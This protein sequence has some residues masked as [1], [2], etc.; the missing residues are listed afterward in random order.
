MGPDSGVK[1]FNSGPKPVAGH[2]YNYNT[3]TGCL[4]LS[5]W[6]SNARHKK[7]GPTYLRILMQL[8]MFHFF[9]IHFPDAGCIKWLSSHFEG[10]FFVQVEVLN[11]LKPKN[12]NFVAGCEIELKTIAIGQCGSQLNL[13]YVY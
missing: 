5:N 7:R 2:N 4:T 3:R 8:Y 9:T 13:S 1:Y 11:V 6:N 12:G 10:F